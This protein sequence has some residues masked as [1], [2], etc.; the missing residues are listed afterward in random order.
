MDMAACMAAAPAKNTNR[1][2]KIDDAISLIMVL[3][4][5]DIDIRIKYISGFGFDYVGVLW[6]WWFI[7]LASIVYS[8]TSN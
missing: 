6:C 2:T 8:A 3:I 4:I 1:A 5:Y 7:H